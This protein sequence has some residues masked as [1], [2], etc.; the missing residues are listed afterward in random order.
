VVLA[1]IWQFRNLWGGGGLS[2]SKRAAQKFDMQIFDL[3]KLK[4]AELKEQ[5]Q[6]KISNSFAALENLD[7]KV[8]INRPWENISENIKISAKESHY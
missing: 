2:A 8:D 7:D 1:A 3:R 4:N 6:V 5:Y